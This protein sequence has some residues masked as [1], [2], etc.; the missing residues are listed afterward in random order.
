MD[1]TEKVFDMHVHFTR[2]IPL[3]ETIEIFKEEFAITGTEKYNFLSAC[4][5][6]GHGPLEFQEAQNVKGLFLKKVVSPNAYAYA[7]LEHPLDVADRPDDELATSYLKQA[8]E[9]YAAGYDGMKMLEGY[10]SMLKAMKRKF[11]DPVYDP[12][13]S[14]LEEKGIP[15]T[16]HIANPETFWDITKVDA[17]S[18]K[19]GRYCDETFPT[20]AQIHQQVD[21]VL[22]KHPR[23]RLVLAHFGF[24]SYDINQAK[25]FLDDYENTMFDLTPGGEQLLK[26]RETWDK[27]WHEFFVKYQDRIIYGTD[28]Y[29]FSKAQGEEAW[30]TAFWR[31][32]RF[33]RQFF[34]TNEDHL[35]GERPF[36][37][38]KIEKSILD[39][40]YR[41]NAVAF[42]GEPRKIDLDYLA[43]KAE[44]R[45]KMPNKKEAFADEDLQY[46]LNNL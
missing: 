9:Y 11:S 2:S 14:F 20:K 10:P 32:P 22:Q 28:F 46:I 35:Y 44:E 36:R 37:G 21:E 15:I 23:L 13:Y 19:A 27:E 16:M 7:H 5:H 33:V 26:M 12:Y 1:I 24:M 45:L 6:A 41:E 4:H 30:K 17:W 8:K 40:I 31:R 3:K 39:K 43:K 25:R 42:L 18:L 38:V 29:A 34:E